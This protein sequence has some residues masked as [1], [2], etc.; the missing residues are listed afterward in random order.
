[1]FD[2]GWSELFLIGVV[3]LIVIGPKDLPVAM[4]AAAKFYNK[5]RGLSHEFQSSVA[6]VMREAELDELRRKVERASRTDPA[7]A[8]KS[9]VD[10]TGSLSADFD[11]AEFAEKLKHTVESGPPTAPAAP[12]ASVQ[13]PPLPP[14]AGDG[15]APPTATR[16]PAD[17]NNG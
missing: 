15:K 5:V 9:V 2:I 16:N 14:D 3:A 6:E 4:R 17:Q 12:E 7:S 8:I 11:P 10:P 13:G 1:M